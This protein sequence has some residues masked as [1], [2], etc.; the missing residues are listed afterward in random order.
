MNQTIPLLSKKLFFIIPILLLIFQSCGGKNSSN[1]NATNYFGDQAGNS[2]TDANTLLNVKTISDKIKEY[3]YIIE[4]TIEIPTDRETYLFSHYID[5]QREKLSHP[6]DRSA[7]AKIDEILT[8]DRKFEKDFY[9]KY[10]NA[11]PI[12]NENN[13]RDNKTINENS[14]KFWIA[15]Q[16][17]Y[18][19]IPIE[20]SKKTV[21]LTLNEV[22]I[23][24]SSIIYGTNSITVKYQAICDGIREINARGN[25]ADAGD[26]DMLKEGDSIKVP[27]NIF[28]NFY[29][30]LDME[31]ILKKNSL[32]LSSSSDLINKVDHKESI[33]KLLQI[34][35][36]KIPNVCYEN[37]GDEISLNNYFYYFDHTLSSCKVS[38]ED[39]S[40][41]VVTKAIVKKPDYSIY[42]EYHRLFSDNKL[43]IFIYFGKVGEEAPYNTKILLQKLFEMGFSTTN[44]ED[45]EFNQY[46]EKGLFKL[47]KMVASE[48]G[49]NEIAL[50][51]TIV[52][53][54]KM[55]HKKAK[56][57]FTKAIATEEIIYYD[58]HAGYGANINEY[59]TKSDTYPKDQY[60][61][62]FLDG[63]NTYYYGVSEILTSKAVRD[64]DF[65]NHNID[66][67]STYSSAHMLWTIKVDFI[68]TFEL[69]AINYKIPSEKWSK[70]LLKE[71]SWYDIISRINKLD[72]AN[73]NYMVSGEQG[74][75]YKP[76]KE[77]YISQKNS[78]DNTRILSDI[79]IY[80]THTIAEK[81]KFFSYLMEATQ[82]QNNNSNNNRS[83]QDIT[84][85]MSELC[86][87]FSIKVAKDIISP[88]FH[89]D[90]CILKKTS[91]GND[92][93]VN[94]QQISNGSTLFFDKNGF[95]N[96]IQLS[97]DTII[98]GVKYKK[99]ESSISR[100]NSGN[101]D[102]YENGQVKRGYLA[103]NMKL[104]DI[105]KTSNIGID[106]DVA[107][108]E[109][110]SEERN[111]S[112]NFHSN[113]MLKSATLAKDTLIKG[114]TLAA[115]NEIE[116]S[117]KGKLTHGRLGKNTIIG[118]ME[119]K[120]GHSIYL[121]ENGE[122]SNTTQKS[123]V[124]QENKIING[125]LYP[126]GT[127]LEFSR[128]RERNSN[129][130]SLKIQQATLII[131]TTINGI[132]LPAKSVVNFSYDK[133]ANIN[134][135]NPNPN[136][137][138][139]EYK[140]YSIE[141]ST[142]Y[143]LTINGVT[144][145]TTKNENEHNYISFYENS[146]IGHAKP[147]N[148]FTYNGITYSKNNYLYFYKSGKL[149]SATLK[150]NTIINSF[151]LKKETNVSFY[152]NGQLQSGNSN[153]EFIRNGITFKG[154]SFFKLHMD[155]SFKSG[156]ASKN[157]IIKN[158]DNL[159]ILPRNV[160]FYPDGNLKMATPANENLLMNGVRLAKKEMLTFHP[161]KRL[162]RARIAED[163]RI[164]GLLFLKFDSENYDDEHG[165][166]DEGALSFYDNGTLM[167]GFL[168]DDSVTTDG[169][170]IKG[171]RNVNFFADGG[172]KSG[173]IIE[174]VSKRGN[175]NLID[176]CT[177]M[178]VLYSKDRVKRCKLNEDRVI[179]GQN[180]PKGT[181][182]KFD[183]KGK[184]IPISDGENYYD[185]NDDN[186]DNDNNDSDI[187]YDYDD[188]DRY[189]D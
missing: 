52:M 82:Q 137:N 163:T 179:E 136:P 34:K 18:T 151:E 158:M 62:I 107:N 118:D 32:H 74:N 112:I 126:K 173:V 125:I 55:E 61:I 10:Q 5:L 67:V 54:E 94:G 49:E 174:V 185:D 80:S 83:L 175:G 21:K 171:R 182:V 141:V 64:F 101:L 104:S 117:E 143:N 59:F 13:F 40:T 109:I 78:G 91:L 121:L 27:R 39:L 140:K 73:A 115:K 150:D 58:G 79:I 93:I 161:N 139:N 189:D 176:F 75:D 127:Y 41:L 147:L 134:I 57:L 36:K 26:N 48:N 29:S 53:S 2:V 14:I 84:K 87:E 9:E 177:G 132:S 44:Q 15:K 66:L 22:V 69:A 8:N 102:F 168:K 38:S 172:F 135:T 96:S 157:S 122:L 111:S 71:L 6:D 160:E 65:L 123:G 68:K 170:K 152:E 131:T 47:T 154:N 90:T 133:N 169:I 33:D 16:I 114:I 81:K 119:Y 120:I 188:D 19:S 7:I 156:R 28:K 86:K 106:V 97:K 116:F 181:F 110:S 180:I 63:C 184:F 56:E 100:L 92:T 1:P 77:V 23:D 159:E 17:K 85:S 31:S 50:N 103:T 24:K 98:N 178:T 148:D 186:D 166:P 72:N 187:N 153:M 164:N 162:K 3:G 95:V 43:D 37:K 128:I 35:N 12:I 70:K 89:P 88:F 138:P 108:T 76:G 183:E 60:Q 146:V 144:Y 20:K 167:S 11:Y 99:S 45:M 130:N 124:I 25:S 155:G 105:V 165:D 4:G 30:T 46:F 129:D 149:K 42:P 51:V 142:P 113:G 145:N